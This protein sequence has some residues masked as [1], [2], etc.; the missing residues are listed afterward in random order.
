MSKTFEID[1]DK[2]SR[3]DLIILYDMIREY[4]EE[5][6]LPEDVESYS[7]DVSYDINVTIYNLN[8][9]TKESDCE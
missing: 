5:Y 1:L 3:R 6:E 2:L 7:Y 4:V 8:E 9:Y